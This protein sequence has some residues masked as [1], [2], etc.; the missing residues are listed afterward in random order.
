M[1]NARHRIRDVVGRLREHRREGLKQREGEVAQAR[2]AFG[3]H[4]ARDRDDPVR[5]HRRLAHGRRRAARRRRDGVDHQPF[6]RA[7]AQ[8]ADQQPREEVVFALRS[9]ARTARTRTRVRSLF[10]PGPL[11][12]AMRASVA[13]TSAI[14][15]VEAPA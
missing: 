6:E 5:D 9:R 1:P 7:L 8:L 3:Q 10:E 11:I 14:V 13:S 15:S 4:G 12:E 2:R